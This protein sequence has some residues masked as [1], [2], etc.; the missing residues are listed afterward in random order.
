MELKF[1]NDIITTMVYR[2]NRMTGHVD[3]RLF[4]S[5]KIVVVHRTAQEAVAYKMDEEVHPDKKVEY[6]GPYKMA[7]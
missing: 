7:K 6:V 5:L 4:L 2:C 3:L 1:T